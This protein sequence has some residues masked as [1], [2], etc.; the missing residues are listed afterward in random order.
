MHA[1]A[2]TLLVSQ[3]N[4]S[5]EA[6][7]TLIAAF[8]RFWLDGSDKAGALTR[9]MRE[10]RAQYPHPFYWAPFMLIGAA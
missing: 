5:D 8:Y 7:V 4:V 3:W 2:R 6:T 9:A 1:G 10:I